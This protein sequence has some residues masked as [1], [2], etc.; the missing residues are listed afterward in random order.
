MR[1]IRTALLSLSVACC[2][3]TGIA[4]DRW[5]G[6]IPFSFKINNQTFPAGAYDISVD[7]AHGVMNLSNY[8]HPGE[9]MQWIGMPADQQNIATLHFAMDGDSYLLMSVAAGNWATHPP[10]KPR[11][12]QE[13]TVVFPR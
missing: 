2:A 10:R 12:T 7:V 4:Q 13:A 5:R 9:H 3:V 11:D 8:L 6:N 1:F